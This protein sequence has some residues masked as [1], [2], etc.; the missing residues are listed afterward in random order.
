MAALR[1]R[2]SLPVDED[3]VLSDHPTLN[4]MLAY[5]TRMQGGAPAPAAEA[6]VDH[7]APAPEPALGNGRGC[8]CGDFGTFPN[9][10]TSRCRSHGRCR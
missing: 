7:P 3:F 2:F 5:L 8:T 4:H 9:A 10:S 1:D 6:A